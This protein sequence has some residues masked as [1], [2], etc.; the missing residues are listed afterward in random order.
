[1]FGSRKFL[2]LDPQEKLA[3]NASMVAKKMKKS[4]PKSPDVGCRTENVLLIL[5]N[6]NL[7]VHQKLR[8]YACQH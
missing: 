2:F 7:I 8:A 3:I 4:A 1:M 5:Q 6:I